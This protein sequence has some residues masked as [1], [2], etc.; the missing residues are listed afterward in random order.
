MGFGGEPRPTVPAERAEPA[1]P[2]SSDRPRSWMQFPRGEA[3]GA[4][5]HG[6]SLAWLHGELTGGCTRW[7]TPVEAVATLSSS[8]GA[9]QRR[10]CPGLREGPALG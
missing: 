5:P 10:R 1:V 7:V 8:G 9:G 3:L 4:D 6:C 2:S